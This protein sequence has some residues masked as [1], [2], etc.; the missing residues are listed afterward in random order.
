MLREMRLNTRPGAR[1]RGRGGCA[2]S[3]ARIRYRQRPRQPRS[4]A[5]PLL[6]PLRSE[7][8]RTAVGRLVVEEALAPLASAA[9][10]D[11]EVDAALHDGGEGPRRVRRRALRRVE[12]R[13]LVESPTVR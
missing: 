13:N 9:V 10:A 11:R 5:A 2:W 7:L 12:T 8:H 1:A 4:R 3:L 6:L